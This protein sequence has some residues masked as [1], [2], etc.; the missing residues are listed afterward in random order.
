MDAG[1]SL[2]RGRF[3]VCLTSEATVLLCPPWFSLLDLD[4]KLPKLGGAAE[5]DS[6]S[7]V[8][9]GPGRGGRAGN[10]PKEGAA[11]VELRPSPEPGMTDE[12]GQRNFTAANGFGRPD[13][14]P[15][16]HRSRLVVAVPC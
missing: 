12:S 10:E 3:A 5:V 6:A 11:T 14:Q 15:R 13:G 2:L 7:A 16:Y 4:G 9:E 1:S 8:R